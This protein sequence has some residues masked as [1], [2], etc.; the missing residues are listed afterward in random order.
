MLISPESASL[1]SVAAVAVGLAA[2][3]VG[4]CATT[5]LV[6]PVEVVVAVASAS[7]DSMVM[8]FVSPIVREPGNCTIEP[9]SVE[10]ISLGTTP[11][12]AAILLAGTSISRTSCLTASHHSR[13]AM[14]VS[15]S[16]LER[17]VRWL[18]VPVWWN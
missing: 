8:V 10:G 18:S 6:V 5:R 4:V 14:T 2:L 16:R 9:G 7:V 1:A 3:V 11:G 15:L 17:P 13:A 12:P